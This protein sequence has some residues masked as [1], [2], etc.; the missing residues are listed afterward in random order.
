MKRAPLYCCHFIGGTD[1]ISCLWVVINTQCSN[2]LGGTSTQTPNWQ[3]PKLL[4]SLRLNKVY[5]CCVCTLHLTEH[6]LFLID[7]ATYITIDKC[8]LFY[9]DI[10]VSVK[11]RDSVS[12]NF[13]NKHGRHCMSVIILLRFLYSDSL[14]LLCNV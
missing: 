2:A 14:V 1:S 4:I 10:I 5:I 7:I 9:C 11:K 8:Q 12:S 13:T 3:T 6:S